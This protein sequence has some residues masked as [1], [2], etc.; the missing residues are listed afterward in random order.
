MGG[1][2]DTYAKDDCTA[3]GRTNGVNKGGVFQDVFQSTQQR[4]P[5]LSSVA[6]KMHARKAK[7]STKNNMWRMKS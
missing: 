3:P 1:N 4:I 6:Q 5:T 7:S 2:Y